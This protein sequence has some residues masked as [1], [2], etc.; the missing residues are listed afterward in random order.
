MGM[1]EDWAAWEAVE[2]PVKRINFWNEPYAEL[3]DWYPWM[4]V[5]YTKWE[6][7]HNALPV[8]ARSL[9]PYRRWCDK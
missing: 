1:A 6:V 9:D 5:F 3:Y 2:L 4:R 7:E 8:S